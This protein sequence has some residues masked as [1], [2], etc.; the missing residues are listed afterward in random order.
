MAK[1]GLVKG[2]LI[3]SVAG[4]IC[5]LLGV[6]FRIPLSNIVG[7]YGI[8]LYQLV[9]PLYSLLLIVSSAGI[10]VALSK[11][12]ARVRD[13]RQQTRQIFV[14]ALV[15]LMVIGIVITLAFLALARPIA[16]WQGKAEIW[17]LYLAI[18]PA[19]W[20]VCVISA[21][22]GYF[23]G[24]NN[25]VPTA[26]SQIVEQAVKVAVGLALAF[27]LI[28]FSI[29][30]AVFGAILAVAVSELVAMLMLM[31]VYAVRSRLAS[32]TQTGD[33]QKAKPKF[34]S[35]LSWQ[36][37]RRIFAISAPIMVMSLAFPLVQLFDSFYVVQALKRSGVEQATELYGIATGAVHT[38]INLPSV[39]G[40][41]IATVML[42]MVSRAY[43]QGD[44]RTMRRKGWTA[45]GI[46]LL[47]GTA[48]AV[49][50]FLLPK[51][52]LTLLYGRAFAGR[53]EELATGI[54][55]LRIESWAVILIG[56]T[57]VAGSILQGCDHEKIPMW[58][59][60]CGGVVKIVFELF[61]LQPL[62][63]MAVSIANLLCYG[64]ALLISGGVL[65]KLFVQRK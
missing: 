65:I 60:I 6:V 38:L 51:F 9:F 45:L 20:F 46:F 63:I 26:V 50:L 5:H 28:R 32:K 42:P 17:P 14:N 57:Q 4:V 40:V 39:V 10:P 7:N 25:M 16:V 21:Y 47:F 53:P 35:L 27:W 56:L 29:L 13:D 33:E 43:K 18:A 12:I 59:L 36:V 22:R 24:L 3:L 23:Q 8:G 1:K 30:W 34:W 31:I 58:A 41:A 64:V 37:I 62:G 49:G 11:M 44:C 2:A 52:I 61:A 55:L 19:V 15:A 54:L 48:V